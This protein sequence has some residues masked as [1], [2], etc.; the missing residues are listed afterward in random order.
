MQAV[1]GEPNL[2][3]RRL[4]GAVLYALLE[5][6]I[7]LIVSYPIAGLVI[8]PQALREKVLEANPV[9]HFATYHGRSGAFL[10]MMALVMLLTLKN[11]V[12]SP[13]W[14]KSLGGNFDERLFDDKLSVREKLAAALMNWWAAFLIPLDIG[15]IALIALADV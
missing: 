5:M 12:A 4:T 6:P 3:C 7:F 13:R 10:V 15:W 2:M 1:T 9:Y 8:G 11:L 14:R